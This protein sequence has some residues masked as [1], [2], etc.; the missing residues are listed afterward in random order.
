MTAL[1][2]MWLVLNPGV[3]IATQA[4]E[5]ASIKGRVTNA[6]TGQPLEFA[7]VFFANTTIGTSTDTSG[8]FE[9]RSVQPGTYML[10]VSLVGFIPARQEVV[11][12]PG[13]VLTRDFGLQ[14]REVRSDEVEVEGEDPWLWRRELGLFTK[15][16]V[17]TTDNS[18]L[19]SIVN[20]QV[21][22]FH[23][24]VKTGFL[25]ADSDSTIIVENRAVGFR[26]Y[27]VLERF[28]W[29]TEQD[30][31]RYAVYPRFEPLVATTP[32]ESLA[33][34]KNRTRTYAGSLKHFLAA[35][36]EGK[37]DEAMFS[38]GTGSIDDLRRGGGQ[39]AQNE[40][41]S[42]TAD[43]AP[44]TCR[45]MFSGW[46]RIDYKSVIPSR[47]SYLKMEAPYAKVDLHGNL[48]TP[49]ALLIAGEWGKSRIADLLPIEG[50]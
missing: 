48:L 34:K 21:I 33:W 7:N 24:D 35:L 42:L 31:G 49:F 28:E 39:V 18:A 32:E 1:L 10:V 25:L 8:R 41:I 46:V 14:I 15:A 2:V 29:D 23:R 5:K 43:V 17:G 20:P 19:C 9:L 3:T 6:A 26:L 50:E 30:I 27:V 47:T 11:L 12:T 22:N 40:E 44:R 45:L 36:I 38:I 37:V 4:R 13:E 16:F